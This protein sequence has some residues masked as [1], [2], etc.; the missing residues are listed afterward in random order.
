MESLSDWLT[1]VDKSTIF[2]SEQ[3][4][5]VEDEE[6]TTGGRANPLPEHVS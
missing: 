6:N 3:E 4:L 1:E 2:L 5:R